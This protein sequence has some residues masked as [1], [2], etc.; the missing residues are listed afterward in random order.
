MRVVLF[1]HG[2]AGKRDPAQWPDDAARPLTERGTERT[3]RAIRGLVRQLDGVNVVL[4]SPLVRAAQTADLLVEAMGK[5]P[6]VETL[7]ALS[8]GGAQR[9]I[10]RRLG[11]ASARH[12]IVLVGHEPDLGK[13]ASAL[14]LG[15]PSPLA[16]KKSG[17]C[18]I[19]FDDAPKLGGGRLEWLLTP[20]LLRRLG[21]D[22]KVRT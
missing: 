13:L 2:P 22:S 12:T 11:E 4:T 18:A 17:A 8:P 7:D 19:V 9:T 3:R 10:L 1:R 21:R 15:A 16:L 14:A 6:A 5:E 20:R